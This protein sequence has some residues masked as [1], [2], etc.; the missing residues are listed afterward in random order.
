LDISS[1]DI[2]CIEMLEALP[3]WH[4]RH[5]FRSAINHLKLG[6]KLYPIDSSMGVFRY[7]TAE[8]EAAS[9]LIKCLIEKGYDNAKKLNPQSHLHK[10]AI[11]P[12]FRAICQ[13]IEDNFRQFDI[14]NDLEI[15]D[16][17]GAKKIRLITQMLSNGQPTI[18]IP[19]PPLSFSFYHQDKRF[20][21]KPQLD[22]LA[23]SKGLKDILAH[24][25]ESA[26]LRNKLLYASPEGYPGECKVE[27]EFFSAYQSRVFAML[28]TYLMIVPYNDKLPFVQDSLDAILT[29]LGTI[30][31][32]NIHDA[33]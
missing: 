12:Y 4:S 28:R 25:K 20:S 26:N 21:Y 2:H 29:M 7:I 22:K 19:E 24:I 17:N 33:Y 3:K 32:D 15:F 16:D 31:L 18:F 5:Y 13:F 14:T 27:P 8:E 10:H 30:M 23:S 9:G 11:I 6:E 1:F